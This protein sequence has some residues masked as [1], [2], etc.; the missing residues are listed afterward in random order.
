MPNH[1]LGH[2]VEHVEPFQRGELVFAHD[3]GHVALGPG[4]RLPLLHFMIADRLRHG[5]LVLEANLDRVRH[6]STAWRFLHRL[7]A[8]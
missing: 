7:V 2:F 5:H 6:S 1:L 4:H 8:N 3:L